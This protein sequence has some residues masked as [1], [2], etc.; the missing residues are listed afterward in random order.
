MSEIKGHDLK[1]HTRFES[2]KI[3]VFGKYYSVETCSVF[4]WKI[5]TS[6]ALGPGRIYNASIINC[7]YALKPDVTCRFSAFG[8]EKEL[9]KQISMKFRVNEVDRN[10]LSACSFLAAS[11]AQKHIIE[12]CYLCQTGSAQKLTTPPARNGKSNL[13]SKILKYL[14][15]T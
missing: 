4:G 1:K 8:D 9:I 11:N 7:G 10:G 2:Y 13:F 3:M 5:R 6:G 14:G 15:L 12:T